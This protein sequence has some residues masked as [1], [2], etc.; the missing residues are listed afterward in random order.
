[1][2]HLD[3]NHIKAR[4]YTFILRRIIKRPMVVRD[5]NGF[6]LT[7]IPEEPVYSLFYN[8]FLGYPEIGE[9]EYCKQA[10]KPGMTVFDVG[11]N[12]GQFTMLFASLVGS[13]GKV[14]AFEPV[15]ETMS[16][17]KV[18]IKQNNL[19]NIITEQAAVSDVH[20]SRVTLNI[21]PEGYSVW[22]TMGNPTMFRRED[23]TKTILPCRQ[24]SVKTVTIDN[25]CLQNKIGKIDY[26]KVDIEGA[27]LNAIRGCSA[28]LKKRAIRKIQFEVSR[29][30]IHGMRLE[31][32]EVFEL[33]DELKYRC[34]PIS[35]KGMLLDPVL[36]SD[37]CFANIIAMPKKDF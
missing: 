6:R 18:H 8:G 30:M 10:I 2:I 7:V 23:P 34:F 4:L 24:E 13:N 11:A 15:A 3:I 21:F 19:K 9:Q 27:E 16:R 25:Y 26:L 22:N 14:V 36:K 20:N 31:G 33:L 5:R 12:L 17:L 37:S 32:S 1:M 29:E 35:D 28:M